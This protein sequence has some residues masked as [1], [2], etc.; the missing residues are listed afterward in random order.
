MGK[1]FGVILLVTATSALG[2]WYSALLG[3]RVRLLVLLDSL[4]D[5]FAIS[6]RFQSQP[7]L[8]LFSVSV[9]NPR[10]GKLSFLP[11]VA[12]GLENGRPFPEV[13]REAL[14]AWKSPLTDS[15]R[16]PFLALAE[17]LGA[18]DQ[19]GQESVLATTRRH[20]AGQAEEARE[21]YRNKGKLYRSL[22]VLGGI[23]LAILLL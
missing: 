11:E 19:Q 14:S 2:L 10:Y 5:D 6:I 22:G 3:E 17:S 12:K 9:G 4:L 7:L 13:W 15:D 1:L 18:S 21:I 8:E 20:I 16:I 23:F